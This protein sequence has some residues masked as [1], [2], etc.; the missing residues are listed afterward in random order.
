M[1]SQLLV[2]LYILCS[3]DTRSSLCVSTPNTVCNLRTLPLLTSLPH[4][5]TLPLPFATA[6]IQIGETSSKEHAAVDAAVVTF[7]FESREVL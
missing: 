6:G 2:P 1:I 4:F 5:L 3:E 7:L